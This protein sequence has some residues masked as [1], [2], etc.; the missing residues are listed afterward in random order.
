MI[1]GRALDFI[2]FDELADWPDEAKI[3]PPAGQGQRT[4][5][6]IKAGKKDPQFLYVS[7]QVKRRAQRK[8]MKQ[9][10]KGVKR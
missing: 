1:R 5:A 4:Q 9:A 2:G 7:R 3:A 6:Q 10:M 8:A